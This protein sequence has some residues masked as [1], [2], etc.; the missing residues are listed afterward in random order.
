[1]TN[2]L[3]YIIFSI[4]IT[5]ICYGQ[6]A[7]TAG[8]F[9]RMG[10]GA[11]G[12]SMGNA[13]TA[14]TT[15]DISTYYNPALSAFSESRRASATFG[16]L[17]LDRYLNFLS[18]TQ[19]IK[20]TAGLSAGIINAGVN[21]ID[22]R[23]R[24]GI[25][26]EEYSTYENQFYLA[27]SNRVDKR[28]SLG[29]AVKLYHSK[30]FEE[31]KSTTVGFDVG[32]CVQIW[33]GLFAGLTIQDIGS[34]YNWDT[35]PL[36]SDPTAGK[37]VIEKFPTLR[38]IGVAYTLPNGM[39]LV[40]VDYENSTQKTGILRAGAEYNFME[41]FSVRSGI[42]RLEFGENATGVKP[43]FGFTVKKSFGEW[44]PAVSYA[45]IF[46]SF[47]PRGIHIITLSTTF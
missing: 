30:L 7:G 14:V 44:T 34:K 40:S 5:V 22:G 29:V 11:R 45:Y 25:R 17:S 36:Y 21:K 4:I 27:F 15:G 28:V 16:F 8:A 47:A 41:Y 43:S 33:D 13:L 26:T 32:A 2:I 35:K 37:T 39:G 12:M 23:D 18:Y 3:K 42:D 9:A 20:P 1:M 19:T 6:N 38:R 46:E 10:F 31:V 24:S